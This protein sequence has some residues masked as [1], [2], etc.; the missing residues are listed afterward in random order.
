MNRLPVARKEIAVIFNKSTA[1][2]NQY[3]NF[4]IYYLRI[5]NTRGC[6]LNW[7]DTCLSHT[8]AYVGSLHNV[9]S[10]ANARTE[11]T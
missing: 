5:A 11:T 6:N 9:R 1:G 8:Y 2:T 4:A 3:I 10:G 7:T